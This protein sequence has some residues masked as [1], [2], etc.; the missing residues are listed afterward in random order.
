MTLQVGLVGSDGIVLASD[1]QINNQNERG[2]WQRY[3]SSKLHV[4]DT[5]ACCW[6]GATLSERAAQ[7][8][9]ESKVAWSNITDA[10]RN[11]AVE[12]CFSLAKEKRPNEVGLNNQIFLAC[13][14]FLAS[15]E[16]GSDG[17]VW[18]HSVK[19]YK[20]HGNMRTTV[21]YLLDNYYAE[22][23]PMSKLII[24]ASHAVCMGE[25]ESRQD[26][27]GLEVAII[28]NGAK[29]YRL[30]DEREMELARISKHVDNSSNE[31]LLRE[32]DLSPRDG[33]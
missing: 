22:S 1:R 30:G 10:K 32:F 25:R 26:V 24:L 12:Q 14:D 8:I 23:L 4:T 28:P 19:A 27:S 5:I 15:Y 17:R 6:A 21:S 13:R 29:P 20:I 11:E 9:S 7:N 3:Q 31:L 16:L 33:G 18:W 2:G